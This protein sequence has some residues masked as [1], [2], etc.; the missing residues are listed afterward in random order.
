MRLILITAALLQ[1]LIFKAGAQNDSKPSENQKHRNFPTNWWKTCQN[2]HSGWFSGEEAEIIA[3]NIISW[4]TDEGGWPLMNT[5]NEPWTGD[6]KAVGP[7]GRN[8]TLVHA[9]TSEIRFLARIYQATRDKEYKEAAENGIRYILK[10]QTPTGGWPKSYP[11]RDKD[12]YKHITFNDGAMINALTLL[13]DITTEPE[14][15]FLDEE[16]K[17]QVKEGYES[18]I[19]CILKC[20]I[21]ANGKLTAWCQQHDEVNY[22]PRAGRTFEPAAISGGESA[23]VLLFLMSIRKPSAEVKKS[24][25]AGVQWYRDVRLDSLELIKTKTDQV[26]KENAAAPPL[27]ARYYE[28]GTNRPIFSGR[29]GVIK[30]RLAEVEPERRR[31]YSWYNYNGAKV[32]ERYAGWK[33]ERK[34]DD[35]PPTN[36]DESKAG[37]YTLPDPLR[38]QNGQQVNSV[39]MWE[40]QRRPEIIALFEQYQHGRKPDEPV[41]STHEI[42]ERD[43]LTPDGM[44]RRTQARITFPGHPDSLKI[45]VTL[46]IPAKAKGP[47]PTLLHISFTPNALLHD[48]EGIDEGLAWDVKR[49]IRIPDRDARHLQD[50]DPKHFIERG[51]AVATV[52]YGDIEPDFDHDGEYGIRSLFS[53]GSS[54]TDRWGAIGAWAWGLSRVMDFLET[55]PGVDKNQVALSGVS[56]LGKTALWAAARDQRFALVIPLL[57]GE[58][59]AAISRRNYGETIADLTNPFRYDYWFAP[60]YA[61]FAFD[62]NDLPVDGHMLLTLIAPRPVLQIVGSEDTWSDPKGEWV[63]AKAAEPVYALYNLKGPGQA[64]FTMP[65]MSIFNDMGFFMHDGKHT[66]LPEDFKAMT[67]FMDLHFTG[68]AVEKVGK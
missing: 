29:D 13:K 2:E 9:T 59:G 11:V 63:A 57:S 41:A 55:V 33:H 53:T 8:G 17:K 47:T 35:L 66:V 25:E 46:K 65:T 32:F 34:W 4:Q 37:H 49:K 26:V 67:D 30:Y 48:E 15:T 38:M 51:Y 6:E 16:L 31:G 28:I 24:I 22:Q 42:I 44:A 52:Y 58:G 54:R 27:W 12:Y 5:T 20:Q 10:A 1:L 18:G 62:P 45:R 36:V 40:N 23:D 68:Q 60:R 61:D 64:E 3:H 14:Y 21:I 50:V 43:A 56:R 7:W 19:D 39:K